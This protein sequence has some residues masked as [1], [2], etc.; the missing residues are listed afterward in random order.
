[1]FNG[2]FSQKLPDLVRAIKSVFDFRQRNGIKTTDDYSA[3]NFQK[4]AEQNRPKSVRVGKPDENKVELAEI[5]KQEHKLFHQLAQRAECPF[6]RLEMIA[7]DFK[8]RRQNLKVS[9]YKTGIIW[10]DQQYL[11]AF[12]PHFDR[13]QRLQAINLAKFDR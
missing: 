5:K 9:F 1:M 3:F 11:F 6:H 2:V 12:H 13:Q 8:F 4:I 10:I 7:G